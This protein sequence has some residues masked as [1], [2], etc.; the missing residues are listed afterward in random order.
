M[1]WLSTSAAGLLLHNSLQFVMKSVREYHRFLLGITL[2]IFPMETVTD[3][4]AISWRCAQLFRVL[5]RFLVSTCDY[6]KIDIGWSDDPLYMRFPVKI[7]LMRRRNIQAE[8]KFTDAETRRRELHLSVWAMNPLKIVYL[9]SSIRIYV[10]FVLMAALFEGLSSIL[11]LRLPVI[12]FMLC[13]WQC[14]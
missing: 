13:V 12:Y 1:P 9:M 4:L 3:S 5:R 10:M 7:R 6:Q 2:L 11:S 14:I 8:Q